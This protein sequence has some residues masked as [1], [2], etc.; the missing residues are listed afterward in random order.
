MIK[1][2]RRDTTEGR[3]LSAII[4]AGF[5]PRLEYEGKAGW[6]VFIYRRYGAEILANG[7]KRTRRGAIIAA[8][9]EAN[10]KLK[11]EAQDE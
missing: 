1:Y 10:Y 4:K 11:A 7:N 5:F 8:I 2:N 3:L 6:Y 9:K